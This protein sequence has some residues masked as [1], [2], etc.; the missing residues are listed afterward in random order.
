MRRAV[1]AD[2]SCTVLWVSLLHLLGIDSTMQIFKFQFSDL[3]Q[4]AHRA[5]GP[6][7]YEGAV[8]NL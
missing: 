1:P 3:F 7:I 4:I 6:R 5:L 2:N 8:R